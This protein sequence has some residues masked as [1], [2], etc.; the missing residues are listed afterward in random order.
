ME[1]ALAAGRRQPGPLPLGGYWT[2]GIRAGRAPTMTVYGV[3]S[4]ALAGRQRGRSSRFCQPGSSG[5]SEASG[6]WACL[7]GVSGQCPRCVAPV[8]AAADEVAQ[9]ECGGAVAEPGVVLGGAQV[10]E[11]EAP[12]TAAGDLGDHPFGVGPV[13]PV[14][15]TQRKAGQPRWRG[16][17][18]RSHRGGAVPGGGHGW[19]SCTGRAAGS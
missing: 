8:Q 9:S 17:H 1:G 13:F 16:P 15:P 12:P 5:G 7:G 4:Q 6:C 2:R 19:Q 3:V 14:V 18:A 11:F 10:A